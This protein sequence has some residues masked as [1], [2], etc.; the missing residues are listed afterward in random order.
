MK[1]LVLGLDG[2]TFRVLTP[3]MRSG[4]M[5]ELQRALQGG[6]WGELLSTKPPITAL[7]WPTFMTGNNPGK[8]GLLSWQAPLNERFERPWISAR[9]IQGAKLWHLLGDAGLR[10][11]VYNVPV[12]Y[13]PEPVNGVMVAGMMTPDVR[14]AFTYPPDLREELLSAF[15]GYQV[16]IDTQHTERDPLNLTHM[17]R[18]TAEAAAV[19]Q[20][21]GEA[22]RWLLARERPDVAVAVFEMPD[23]LQHLL[24]K[25][26]ACLPDSHPQLPNAGIMRSEL[27][28]CF[29][30]L[31]AE[32]GKL[33]QMLPDDAHLALV[34]DHGFGPI[35]T[36]V[37]LNHWLAGHGWLRFAAGAAGRREAL[38][39]IGRLVK[40]WLPNAW[41]RRARSSFSVLQTVDWQ[42]T[43]AYAGLPSEYGVFLNLRGREPAGTIAPQEYAGLR[44]EIMEALRGWRD[45]RTGAHLVQ[46]VH[47][48]EEIYTGPHV[49]Q[50]P[51]ILIEFAPGY[52]V[53]FL[54]YQGDTLLD[55]SALPLGFH[56]PEGIFALRGPGVAQQDAPVSARIEDVLPTLLYALQIPVP[57]GLDGAAQVGL[58]S[59]EWR[60]AHPLQSAEPVEPAA[61]QSSNQPVAVY[62]A[63][64]EERL[65]RR[66]KELGYLN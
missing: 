2:A 4:H 59:T 18:L 33:L 63:E 62:S 24:W 64:E 46:Q 12:T 10:V 11:C 48:R 22:L 6:V 49:D 65:A 9:Q 19:T 8:H 28:R 47:T 13:P 26:I 23:R 30:V 66:L 42:Q 7:A 41:M 14:S 3:L 37:H 20:V 21:R 40:R 27:L 39:R 29:S 35:D 52:H 34:S 57:Q 55:V 38:R 32:M 58:F 16:D 45:P 1:A 25:Y 53:A 43:R 36:M 5:P 44:A 61:R 51:D 56:E 15:P 60:A 31:D 50:A 54:P 17:Q